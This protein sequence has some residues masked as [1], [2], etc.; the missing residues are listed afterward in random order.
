M[1][2]IDTITMNAGDHKG[3]GLKTTKVAMIMGAI[4]GATVGISLTPSS[5][6]F[7][8]MAKSAFIGACAGASVGTAGAAI[9]KA[10]V[11]DVLA[12]NSIPKQEG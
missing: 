3:N 5:A 4:S 9:V 7:G 6:T 12:S 10:A 11:A 8:Q 1:K 2:L